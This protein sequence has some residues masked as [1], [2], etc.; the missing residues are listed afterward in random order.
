M[1]R[2]SSYVILGFLVCLYIIEKGEKEVTRGRKGKVFFGG[3]DSK[4]DKQKKKKVRKGKERKGGMGGKER[5]GRE[6]RG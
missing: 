1:A 4:T 5:V 6:G 2:V 3:E